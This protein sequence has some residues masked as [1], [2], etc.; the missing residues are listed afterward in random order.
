MG[1]GKSGSAA[2]TMPLAPPL[3]AGRTRGTQG[4]GILLQSTL[5]VVWDTVPSLAQTLW[6][7]LVRCGDCC[8]MVLVQKNTESQSRSSSSS[9]DEGHLIVLPHPTCCL[10]HCAI[11]CT[12][13]VVRPGKVC[14]LLFH[15]SCLEKH[16][17]RCLE[18]APRSCKRKGADGDDS[19]DVGA[20]YPGAD[21]PDVQ[22]RLEHHQGAS[23]VTKRLH[24]EEVLDIMLPN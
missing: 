19:E 10:E 5:Y 23:T 18:P 1:P 4:L 6:S 3:V 24:S 14:G 20:H 8:F 21:R 17:K 12:N 2:G 13:T 15:A 11:S 9:P 22:P 16:R 7:D